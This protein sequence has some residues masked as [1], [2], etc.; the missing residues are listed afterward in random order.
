MQLHGNMITDLSI[1]LY[2]TAIQFTSILTCK[3]RLFFFVKLTKLRKMLFSP[4]P[5]DFAVEAFPHHFVILQ[6]GNRIENTLST[7]KL[8]RR[9]SQLKMQLMRL[10]KESLKKSDCQLN[11]T[12]TDC[13]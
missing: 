6:I 1:K 2:C 12:C 11:L 3:G 5:A 4:S 10:R 13:T 7:L 8:Q 9:S